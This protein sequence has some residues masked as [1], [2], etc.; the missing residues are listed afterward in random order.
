MRTQKIIDLANSY[1]ACTGRHAPNGHDFL[2]A[3][4]AVGVPEED[5][6]KSADL[7]MTTWTNRQINGQRE[8]R[9]GSL[10]PAAD[11]LRAKIAN[12]EKQAPQ[13]RAMVKARAEL[14][15]ILA[16]DPAA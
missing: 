5:V 12:L 14:A 7:A 2:T 13:G 8:S 11:A 15:E 1:A 6:R 16:I 4:V 9:P 3:A 10:K